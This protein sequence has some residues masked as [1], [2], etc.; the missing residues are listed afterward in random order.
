LYLHQNQVY[1][2]RCYLSLR[3]ERQID[4]FE[5]R[6]DPDDELRS[7][8]EWRSLRYIIKHRLQPA[9]NRLWQPDLVNYAN[10]RNNWRVCH[11]HV[12]PRYAS[13]RSFAGQPFVDVRWG[14]NWTTE[15]VRVLPDAILVAIRD[16]LRAEIG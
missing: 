15:E 14:R 6:D 16:A 12:V 11:W 9:L 10:L 5:F 7:D 1:L 8:E 2:G 3:N 4:P 13:A